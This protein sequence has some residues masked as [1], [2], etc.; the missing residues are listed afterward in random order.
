MWMQ[1]NIVARI[2]FSFFIFHRSV[3]LAFVDSD[4]PR[5]FWMVLLFCC[6]FFCLISPTLTDSFSIDRIA[7]Y[8]RLNGNFQPNPTQICVSFLG[9]MHSESLYI[10]LAKKW[11]DTCTNEKDWVIWVHCA[12]SSTPH[13]YWTWMYMCERVCVPASNEFQGSPIFRHRPK[14][15]IKR[16]RE[17]DQKAWNSN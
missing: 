6:F 16:G 4:T 12:G 9:K 3:L 8:S 11:T 10:Y 1:M 17:K 14:R 2:L 7:R 13:S 5:Q 15:M